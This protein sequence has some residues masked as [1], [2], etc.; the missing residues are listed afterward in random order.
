MTCERDHKFMNWEWKIL[1][2]WKYQVPR[3]FVQNTLNNQQKLSERQILWFPRFHP[4]IGKTFAVF[5]SPVLKVPKKAIAQLNIHLENFWKSS[6]I[7]ENCTSFLLCSFCRL[8]YISYHLEFSSLIP[9][10][11]TIDY[12]CMVIGI[13]YACFT[14]PIT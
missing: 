1:M 12:K 3:C 9:P 10:N 6:K 14:S 11:A 2:Q 5:A 7:C 8:Q 13:L 4:N